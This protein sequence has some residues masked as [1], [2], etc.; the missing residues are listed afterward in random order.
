[1]K[2]IFLFL[3]TF[4]LSTHSFSQKVKTKSGLVIFDAVESTYEPV[5][6]VNTAT[7][8]ILNTRNGQ[9]A[10]QI[11]MRAFEFK[12]AL[13]EEHFNENYLES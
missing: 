5:K 9:I 13:M 7:T 12:V 3:L 11:L 6:A 10:C 1:M 8:C 2:N 4:L